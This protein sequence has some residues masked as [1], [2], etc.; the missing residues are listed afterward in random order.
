MCAAGAC[1]VDPCGDVRCPLGRRC[2][3]GACE[4]DP[5]FGLDCPPGE[6]CVVT[7][8][9]AQ[10]VLAENRPERPDMGTLEGD[11]ALVDARSLD[12]A[13]DDGSVIGAA[14]REDSTDAGGQRR[15][16]PS[17]AGCACSSTGATDSPA[18][19]LVGLG[20]AL[21]RRRRAYR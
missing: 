2:E 18:L 14:E 5:C 11:A 7:Q 6:A 21:R 3:A 9:L 20:L 13:I 12:A 17:P 1:G 16:P 8:G 10:C 15:V 4:D 19:L